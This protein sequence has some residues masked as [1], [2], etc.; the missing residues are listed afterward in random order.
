MKTKVKLYS[1]AVLNTLEISPK[2]TSLISSAFYQAENHFFLLL[3]FFI[4]FSKL[5]PDSVSRLVIFFDHNPRFGKSF[6]IKLQKA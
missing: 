5:I 4:N 6:N 1:G 3:I 2:Q